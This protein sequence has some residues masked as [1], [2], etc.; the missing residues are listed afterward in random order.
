MSA[1]MTASAGGASGLAS[2]A[3]RARLLD[4]VLLAVLVGFCALFVVWPIA[5]FV[6]QGLAPAADGSTFASVLA[7]NA[8][9]LANSALVGVLASVL[10]CVVALA[11]ALVITF[12]PR[13]WS[14]VVTG[15]VAVSMISPPFV[16][17]L[18]YVELFGRRGLITHGILGLS[19]SPYGWQGVV[20]MQALFFAAI[21]VILFTSVLGRVDRASIQAALDLGAPMRRVFS[22]I[23]VPL[24]RP[25]TYVCLLLT[26]VRS[27][28]D[29]ATPVVIG[30]KFDTVATQI[31]VRVVGYSDLRGA[32]MLNVLLFAVS[33]A[34]FLAYRRLDAGVSAA[35]GSLGVSARPA[36]DEAGFRLTG[37]VGV[38]AHVICALFSAFLAVLYLTIAHAAF[39][40]G[41]GWSAPFTLEN[42]EHLM[43]F[44]L[45]SLRRS[46]VFSLVTALVSTAL[47][48]LAAYYAH[49]RR[50]RASVALDFVTTVA[51]T[52]PG[53]CLGLGYILAF[54]RPPVELVGTSA[55][56][57]AVLVAKELAISTRAF[58]SALAQ[59]PAELDMAAADLG[60]PAVGILGRVLA[61]NL[62]EAAGV[63]LVNGFSSAMVSYS[64]VLFL[65]TPANK[66]AVFELFDAL[67]GGKYGDAAMVSLAIIVVTTLVNVIFYKFLLKGRK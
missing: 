65:V 41:M 20:L 48:L 44:D 8:G 37:P 36:P 3:R 29:Y 53:I 7:D 4:A 6:W 12:G 28:S 24:V 11:V 9:L 52:L 43:T 21:N 51:Y 2:R 62:L 45:G 40:R 38:A 27:V 57:I 17:S 61:P 10:S 31:Y 50:V 15:L 33:V 34:A 16:A 46:I 19:V 55:I 54:N 32:A 59:V 30:G 39:T 14:R 64:A 63:S 5:C 35:S 56:L 49:R 22:D 26:F 42:L 66:T 47:G 58:S 67:S 13:L 23:I 1:G 18:A 60:T 25:A